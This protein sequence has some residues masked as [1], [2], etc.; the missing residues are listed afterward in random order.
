M[1]SSA[2]FVQVWW[3]RRR[4]REEGRRGATGVVPARV[5]QATPVEAARRRGSTG[6]RQRGRESALLWR[7]SLKAVGA[8]LAHVA[9][10]CKSVCSDVHADALAPEMRRRRKEGRTGARSP[11]VA[12]PAEEWGN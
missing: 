9:C 2:D 6:T 7:S 8:A 4:G 12:Q 1:K 10:V 5:G 11:L 3:R